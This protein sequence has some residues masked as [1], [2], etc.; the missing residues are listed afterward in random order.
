LSSLGIN[1][2]MQQAPAAGELRFN[3]ANASDE[4]TRALGPA[5]ILQRYQLTPSGRNQDSVLLR[6][7]DNSAWAVSGN[8]S[9]GGR[10]VLIGSP[11]IETST[12]LPATPAM[13]PL[14]DRA[15]GVWV[16]GAASTDADSLNFAG[17]ESDLRYADGIRV[18]RMLE[19]LEVKRAVDAGS[20]SKAIFTHRVGKEIWRFLLIALFLI[21]LVESVA[22]ATGGVRAS[23]T[24]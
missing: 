6:L 5:R 1:W 11:L 13:I 4:L 24:D 19:P 3:A 2:Q 20:W 23:A 14:F 7:E 9:N 8:R 18:A 16:S 10:F 12:N 21:L 15:T 22:A 17:V